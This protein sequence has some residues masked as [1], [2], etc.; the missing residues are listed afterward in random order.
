MSTE[1]FRH[2]FVIGDDEAADRMIEAM[3]EANASKIRLDKESFSGELER[4]EA[5]LKRYFSH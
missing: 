2:P 4:G 1:S 5:F 3:E